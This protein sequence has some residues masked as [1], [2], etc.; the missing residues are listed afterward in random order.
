MATLECLIVI[1]FLL[2][3]IYFEL[4]EVC[5]YVNDPNVSVACS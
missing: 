5:S 4:H 1:Y 3:F 2:E